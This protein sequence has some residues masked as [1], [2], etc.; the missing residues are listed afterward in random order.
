MVHDVLR[1]PGRPLPGALHRDM[2]ARFGWDFSEVRVHSDPSADRSAAGVGAT[3]YTVGTHIVL[4]QSMPDLDSAPGRRILTHELVH[5]MQQ[6]DAAPTG[7]LPVS[8]PGD[9]AERE[10]ADPSA[11]TAHRSVPLS[12]QR[13][14]EPR[15]STFSAASPGLLPAVSVAL[16]PLP[17]S[18]PRARLLGSYEDTV[19]SEELYGR[20]GVPIRYTAVDEIEVLYSS[21]LP[22]WK[23]VFREAASEFERVGAERRGRIGTYRDDKI[24]WADRLIWKPVRDVRRG[25][26]VIGYRRSSGGYTEV[27][28][29]AGELMGVHEIPI[30]PVRIPIL[31]DVLEQAGYA[32][33][34]AV[35]TWLEDNWRALGLPPQDEPLARLFQIPSDMVAYRIGRGAGHALSLLQAGA[36]LVGGAA[37]IVGGS[38]EFLVGV[39]TTPAGV[40]LVVMPVGAVTVAAGTTVLVHGGVLA[41]AVFMSAASGGG[42]SGEGRGWGRGRKPD[43]KQVDDVA[44]QYGI[45][46][47]R[48]GKF[49]EKEKELGNGGTANDRG[50]F[51]YQELRQKAVEFLELSVK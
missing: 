9:A 17:M 12:V 42:G 19:I 34:G 48:F 30:E 36:E 13:E 33:V 32:L 10:A 26:M 44:R 16:E 28:N 51:T 29:T 38:G 43:N 11:R 24:E 45:D 39:A 31:D 15:P 40:G 50:D 21:L 14:P 41:G 20:P 25:G 3:A 27:R 7:P 2:S 5:V 23:Q 1:D 22:E 46:R 35:D 6:P 49:I 8:K 18:P 47:D 37:L 4:G